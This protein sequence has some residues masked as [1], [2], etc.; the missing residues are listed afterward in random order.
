MGTVRALYGHCVCAT[1]SCSMA[2]NLLLGGGKATQR[3]AI[4]SSAPRSP[5]TNQFILVYMLPP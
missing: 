4:L 5:T 1:R 3:L 2:V